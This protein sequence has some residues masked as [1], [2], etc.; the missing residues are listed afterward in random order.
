MLGDLATVPIQ[1][2]S[3][4]DEAGHR[5]ELDLNSVPQQSLQKFISQRYD[6]KK[7]PFRIEARKDT[8]SDKIEVRYL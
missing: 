4:F 3:L 2:C 5:L 7:L 6:S 1:N 8:N